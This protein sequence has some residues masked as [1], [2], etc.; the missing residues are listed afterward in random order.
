MGESGFSLPL[1]WP[2]TQCTGAGA[3]GRGPYI[4]AGSIFRE[5]MTRKW[6]LCWPWSMLQS[7]IFVPMGTLWFT[8]G[9]WKKGNILNLLVEITSRRNFYVPV[10]LSEYEYNFWRRKCLPIKLS[11]R[12]DLDVCGWVYLRWGLPVEATVAS[13]S[14]WESRSPNTASE[15]Q[16]L[17]MTSGRYAQFMFSF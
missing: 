8:M 16:Q 12:T 1:L 14:K 3:A 4:P 6:L 17:S 15:E 9:K 13:P 5:V 2:S 11:V 7:T 10:N